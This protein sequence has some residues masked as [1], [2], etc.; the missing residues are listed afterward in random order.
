MDTLVRAE[1]NEL[2]NSLI[3]FIKSNFK[4]K[5]IAVHIYE[6]EMDETEYLLSDPVRREKL[7]ESAEEVN[8]KKDM[9]VYSMNELKTMFLNEPEP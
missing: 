1:A 2:N 3:D 9:K 6:D 8:E 7:L 4:N 5:K